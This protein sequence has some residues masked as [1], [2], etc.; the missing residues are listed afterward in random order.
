MSRL[1]LYDETNRL[2][3]TVSEAAARRI[4]AVKHFAESDYAKFSRT[5]YGQRL[6]QLRSPL[7]VAPRLTE[8]SRLNPA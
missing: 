2:V 4:G 5:P 7:F 3:L 8:L 1:L 6:K